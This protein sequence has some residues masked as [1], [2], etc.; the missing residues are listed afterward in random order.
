M[1]NFYFV[2]VKVKSIFKAIVS[3]NLF[4][5]KLFRPDLLLSQLT[6]NVQNKLYNFILY[7]SNLPGKGLKRNLCEA[8]LGL[9]EEKF[10]QNL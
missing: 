10:Y 7:L 9:I 6:E 8:V 1:K 4:I 3:P 5:S 2:T